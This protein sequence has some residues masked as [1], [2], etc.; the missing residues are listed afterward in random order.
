MEKNENEI[1]KYISRFGLVWFYSISTIVHY[2][3]LNPLYIYIYIY[4][5]IGFDLLYVTF[6]GISTIVY[7]LMPNH[8]HT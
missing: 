3:M 4:I 1:N 7:Y 5:Y 6:Y 2:L 8:L